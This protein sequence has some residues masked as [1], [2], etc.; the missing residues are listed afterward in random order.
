MV[1]SAL[2]DGKWQHRKF[3]H[4]EKGTY[5]NGS[6][7]F[8]RILDGSDLNSGIDFGEKP[9]CCASRLPRIR[10]C[11]RFCS[12]KSGERI[13]AGLSQ[14]DR[15]SEGANPLAACRTSSSAL[16]VKMAAPF[17]RSPEGLSDFRIC[18]SALTEG[19]RFLDPESDSHPGTV[20][21]RASGRF[22]HCSEVCVFAHGR[23]RFPFTADPPL[24]ADFPP[25]QAPRLRLLRD[26]RKEC[27]ICSRWSRAVWNP[28]WRGLQKAGRE[29]RRRRR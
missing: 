11:G 28:A 14:D 8:L 18:C 2:I 20:R 26:V 12:L 21:P 22:E 17:W 1:P 5:E 27:C 25:I 15:L 4:V 23:F 6:F 3:V 16:L 9:W 10:C 24:G 13:R 7:K 29:Q 19:V